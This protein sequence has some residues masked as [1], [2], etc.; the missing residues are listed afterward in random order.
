MNITVNC[1]AN[2]S[3]DY[4]TE[5]FW[6]TAMISD[7]HRAIGI[8]IGT[9]MLFFFILGAPG[10]SLIIFSILRHK[11][12]EQPTL[13]ILLNLAVVDLMA[14][15]IILPPTI[16]TGIGGE[17]IFGGS[18]Y[19][20]CK[21]C[22][23][24]LFVVMLSI[25]NIYMMALLSIDR[26]ILIKIPLR[27]NK[28][29]T[30]KLTMLAVLFIWICL[31]IL[32]T[33]PSVFNFGAMYYDHPTLTCL[34][35][36]DG[37]TN[38]T[39]NIYYGIVC[40][41]VGL[42][43]FIVVLI[44]NAW[45]IIIARRQVKQVYGVQK[46]KN[47]KLIQSDSLRNIFK[48]KEN[49]KQLQLLRV[50]GLILI[51]NLITWIPP[52]ARIIEA[53]IRPSDLSLWSNFLLIVSLNSHCVVHPFLQASLIPEIRHYLLLPTNFFRKSKAIISMKNQ[54]KKVC[55]CNLDAFRRCM[56]YLNKNLM[57]PSDSVLPSD[58]VL[59]RSDAIPTSDAKLP[60]SDVK[61][62]SSDVKLNTSDV[63]LPTSDA[64]LPI[65]NITSFAT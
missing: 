54:I 50:F 58:A 55:R 2:L 13:L 11:L 48:N 65:Y 23:L 51:S 12:Y 33:L 30:V 56:E 38:V 41:V 35:Q 39:L 1:N 28:I 4:V 31:T 16:I 59:S 61:L 26:L 53:A 10:N 37:E 7:V 17:Y 43:A 60:T 3:R 25:G 6:N 42:A 46:N 19:D 57:D 27:Y 45:I 63:K 5:E 36:F 18:D 44:A 34:P 8:T 24:G 21:V 64:K 40:F 14:C 29:V 15:V 52:L 47:Q 20:R 9:I 49:K 22:Q 32:S 62:P